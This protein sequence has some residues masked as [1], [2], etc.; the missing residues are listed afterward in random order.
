MP[1]ADEFNTTNR[2]AF[3]SM[4]VAVP[5]VVA[6]LAPAAAALADHP[7]GAKADPR[8]T[9]DQVAN[10]LLKVNIAAIAENDQHVVYSVRVPREALV[11]DPYRLGGLNDD[12]FGAD[13]A[14]WIA[15]RIQQI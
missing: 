6:G 14:A 9:I 8:A 2:R 13:L 7:A 5:A 3:L 11:P 1:K 4:A 10:E 15:A 12:K